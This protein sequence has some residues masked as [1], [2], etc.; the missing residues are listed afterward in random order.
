MLAL[1]FAP[2]LVHAGPRFAVVAKATPLHTAADAKSPAIA[3]SDRWVLRAV[4]EPTNGWVELAIDPH[5]ATNPSDT[6]A[7]DG[8]RHCY[9]HPN[10]SGLAL[11][12]FARA[13][14]LLAVTTR[15]VK[16]A[17]ADGTSAE[18]MPGV[19]VGGPDQHG[20]RMVAVDG[21]RVALH[22]PDGA[23]G[24]TYPGP[25]ELLPFRYDSDAYVAASAKIVID[26]RRRR[27]VLAGTTYLFE[28]ETHD[29]KTF[30]N[31]ANACVHIHA[32]IR[33]P[34]T[35]S[36]D[37]AGGVVGHGVVHSPAAMV[38]KPGSPAYWASGAVAGTVVESTPFVDEQPTKL[39]DRRCFSVS[40]DGPS[41][42]I[43]SPAKRPRVTVCFARSD[44]A[45]M[46]RAK[47]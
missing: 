38:T 44:L 36:G 35:R 8:T 5:I 37:P 26:E 24:T 9:G 4:G 30:A 31:L 11:H 40:I 18:I 20:D 33:T 28:P 32:E 3:A 27:F 7:A 25:T 45:P 46:P 43:E 14:R 39:S 2:A 47:P 16:L 17:F 22:L 34:T 13:N 15:D 29:G 21:A 23:V 10:G 1:L 41:G 42:E 19:V 6:L 12:F